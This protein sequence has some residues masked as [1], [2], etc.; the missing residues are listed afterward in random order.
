MNHTHTHKTNKQTHT[1]THRHTHTHT[2]ERNGLVYSDEVEK[3][4]K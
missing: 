3:G 2:L 4:N 1:Q